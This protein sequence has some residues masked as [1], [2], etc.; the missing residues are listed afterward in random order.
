LPTLHQLQRTQRNV[1]LQWFERNRLWASPEEAHEALSAETKPV[2]TPM[3]TPE[4]A[5]ITRLPYAPEYRDRQSLRLSE[6]S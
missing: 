3:E 1:T 2:E 6:A 5:E 4:A